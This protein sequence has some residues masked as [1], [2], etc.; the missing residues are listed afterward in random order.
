MKLVIQSDDYGMT[1]AVADGIIYGITHGVVR[2]T[3]L[4]SNMPWVEECVEKIKPYLD[5]IAF[6]IDLNASTGSSLLGYDKVPNLCHPDGS[7]LTS[8]ENRAADVE[9][10][11]H[12]HVDH[13][14]I[15]AEFDAQIQK[16]ITLV[17]KTPDYIHGHAYGTK[18]TSEVRHELARKYDRPCTEDVAMKLMGQ[19]T[20]MGWYLMGEGP[21]GQLKEDP[22]GFITEDK[23]GLLKKE[24]GYIITHCGYADARLFGLSS[25]NLCRVKDLEACTSDALKQ[26]AVKNDVTFIS[27]NDIDKSILSD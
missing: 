10:P 16:Y 17:G 5:K 13:N 24:Y 2:N 6:G 7:F 27:F 9:A 8:K 25:F 12:D 14:Q 18:T 23:A 1:P 20:P 15:Y 21:E 11:D 22:L 26:W 4:F 19:N 3:G